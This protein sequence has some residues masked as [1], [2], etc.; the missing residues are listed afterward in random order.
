MNLVK[1]LLIIKMCVSCRFA[2][3]DSLMLHAG[4]SFLGGI[5]LQVSGVGENPVVIA[6]Y[7]GSSERDTA[8]MMNVTGFGNSKQHIGVEAN[9][10]RPSIIG[11]LVRGGTCLSIT[12]GS[13]RP[14]FRHGLPSKEII[15]TTAASGQ[16][17]PSN[18]L[19]KGIA[20]R[21]AENG[22]SFIYRASSDQRAAPYPSNV[23]QVQ[24]NPTNISI[25]DCHFDRIQWAAPYP[26]NISIV[27][28]G[29][30]A[31]SLV[32]VDDMDRPAA[33]MSVPIVSNILITKCLATEVDMFYTNRVARVGRPPNSTSDPGTVATRGVRITGNTIYNSSFNQIVMD[34]TVD[35]M[36]GT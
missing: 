32:S 27:Y 24:A 1:M 25:V 8:N 9:I 20:F 18:I 34:S 12:S 35:M 36:I 14:S 23:M 11:P 33:E 2:A 31:I 6:S 21:D 4:D 30:R 10:N 17:G 29:G 5:S 13:L 22:L 7:S 28:G 16:Q 19:V 15:R 26:Q 3:G